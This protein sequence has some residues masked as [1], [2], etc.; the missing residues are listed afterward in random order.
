MIDINIKIKPRGQMRGRAVP[1]PRKKFP[2]MI[3]CNKDFFASISAGVIK[4]KKQKEYE[5]ELIRELSPFT[6][7]EV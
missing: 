5:A 7:Y 3:S 6:P 1:R 2:I 4:D